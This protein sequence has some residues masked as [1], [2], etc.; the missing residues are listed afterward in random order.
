MST[1]L[2]RSRVQLELGQAPPPRRV[3]PRHEPGPNGVRYWVAGWLRRLRDLLEKR[4]GPRWRRLALSVQAQL[5]SQWC[6][7]ACSTSVS[8][9]YDAG[10]GWSQCTVVNAEL[11]QTSC[12]QDG[13][14]GHCNRPWYLDRALARTGNLAGRTAGTAPLSRIRSQLNAGRPVGARIGW[15]G[16]GGHFVMIS[17][18]LD[19]ATGMVEVRDPIYGTSELSIA[20]FASSYQ[21]SGSWTHTY[22]TRPS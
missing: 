22:Y 4:L 11:A 9:F 12:C 5:Q 7:A 19:D 16:C 8:H 20:G 2:D 1:V 14:T 6:W 10:S 3:P 18:C 15:A 17:G 13:A 21:G